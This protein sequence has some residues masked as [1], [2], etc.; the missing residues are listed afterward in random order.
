[1]P[2]AH[3]MKTAQAILTFGLAVGLAGCLLRAKQPAANTTPPAPQPMAQPQPAAAAQ[4]Q[5]LSIPQTQIELPPPQPVSTEAI[6][7]AQPPD[8]VT[9]PP[10]APPRGATGTHRGSGGPPAAAP[11]PET[12]PPSPP[13]ANPPTPAAAPEPNPRI[14]EIVPPTEQK[15]LQDLAEARKKES[16][17]LLEQA[18]ARRLNRRE[19]GLKRSIESF[20]KL[21][22]QAETK[23]DMRQAADYADRA[24]TLAKDLQS[25]R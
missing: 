4:P 25:G 14:Q 16:R 23:G 24:L 18:G 19:A 10:A 17:Q 7:A 13:P 21:C 3:L 6:A 8:E 2:R 9:E 12:P 20:L 11:K 5:P 15:R 1:M 22:D